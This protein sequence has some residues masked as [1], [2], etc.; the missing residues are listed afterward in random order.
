M[1]GRSGLWGQLLLTLPRGGDFWVPAVVR[2]GDFTIAVGT[3]GAARVA[4]RGVG[5]DWKAQY[6]EIFGRWVVLLAE[7][8]PLVRQQIADPHRRRQAPDE[9]TG[10][11]W[12]AR[13]WGAEGLESVRAAMH[14]AGQSSAADPSN[15]AL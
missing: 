6:D 12:L 9:L 2:Q 4:R 1:P 5:A 13:G 8:R 15:R 14:C 10:W 11:P 7:L 3:G